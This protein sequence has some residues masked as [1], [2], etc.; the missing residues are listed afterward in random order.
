MPRSIP[1]RRW[2]VALALAIVAVFAGCSRQAFR[3][4]ADRDVE[5]V[6]GQKNVVPQWEVKN[7]HVYPDSRARFSDTGSPDFPAYPPDDYAAKVLSPNPQRPGQG[8]SGRYEG[9]GWLKNLQEW[10]ATNRADD[11]TNGIDES[12]PPPPAQPNAATIDDER[13]RFDTALRTDARGYR[14]RLDQAVELGLYNSREFQDRREDLYLSALPVTLQRFG[15]AAQAI[16]ASE[17]ILSVANQEQAAPGTRL[18]VNTTA[19]LS[20]R[21]STGAALLVQLANRV[22]VDLSSGNPTISVSTLGLSLAV[23]FLRG[24][25][26]AVTLEPLT[27]AERNLLYAIRSYAR[28]RSVFYVAVAGQ[29][30]YTNNPYGL[31]GLA[32]NLG[33]GV[34]ANL[35]ANPVGYLPTI[36]RS[37]VLNNERGNLASFD[38]Y[39]RLF[40]SLEEGGIVTKL[41]VGRIEQQLLSSR[42]TVLLRSQEYLD[43]IDNFKLQLGMPATV[44]LELDETPLR[45]IRSHLRKV[46]GVYAQLREFEEAAVKLDPD[47]PGG[48]FR[49]GWVK[50]LTDSAI[51]RGTKLS[52]EY[53]EWLTAQAGKTDEQLGDALDRLRERRRT[54]LEERDRKLKDGKAADAEVGELEKLDA[55]YDRLRF[56]LAVRRAEMREWAKE[57]DPDKRKI[58]R[59][60]VLRDV[61]NFGTLV[62]V[63][64]R[65]EK[66][67]ALRAEWAD[68]PKIVIDDVDVLRAPLD[69]GLEKVAAVALNNRFDLMNARAQVVDAWRQVTVTANALQG[70]FDVEYELSTNSPPGTGQTFALGG[71]RTLNQVRL[72]LEPPFVR[73]L[74]RNNYRAALVA[75]QRQRRNLMAFEDNIATDVRSELRQVRQLEQ[76]LIVQQRAVELA[77]QQVDN[78]RGT[79]LA[80]PDPRVDASAAAAAQTEQ[81]LQVQAALVRAQNDLFTTWVRYL[82]ARMNLYLDLELLTLDARGIWCD[83]PPAS[84]PAP[85]PTPVP[86]GDTGRPIGPRDGGPVPRPALPAAPAPA[87]P[88]AGPERLPEPFP[89]LSLPEPEPIGPSRTGGEPVARPDP[90]PPVDLPPL[91]P[92]GRR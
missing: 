24:G 51:A 19:G 79:L 91:D 72:R 86:V 70:V 69:V 78:A 66:L 21:F 20:R 14:L 41:Q 80:P 3:D 47:A 48:A 26:F 30:D 61:L 40:R 62:A 46:E 64:A 17:A 38:S 76:A 59:A 4:R 50:L 77:Y 9:D 29:G 73:R 35:T 49:E 84:A 53:P 15:F 6:I 37:A 42:A 32:Q 45:P 55:D 5:A 25:G 63:P 60:L 87:A 7:W 2:S 13:E 31:Q 33:R 36:L 56:E 8:G 85:A 11:A 92:S 23:P 88:G 27:Q 67:A 68:V 12:T 34:G 39:L 18:N 16:A 10:D 82:T 81:L 57:A 89:I 83:E 58:A 22:V 74:E 28:F 65:N 1:V 90:F 44:P 43:N 52:K 71:S 54:L 75:Y